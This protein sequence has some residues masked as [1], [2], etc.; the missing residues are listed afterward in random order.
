MLHVNMKVLLYLSLPEILA[1]KGAS[2]DLS[3][4]LAK[5]LSTD[6][7]QRCILLINDQLS[8]KTLNIDRIQFFIYHNPKLSNSLQYAY[9][10]F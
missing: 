7:P 8:A 1:W 9:F 6:R 5:V 10:E 4:D 2:S 3:Y